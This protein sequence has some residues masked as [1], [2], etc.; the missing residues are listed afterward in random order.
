MFCRKRRCVAKLQRVYQSSTRQNTRFQHTITTESRER[1]HQQVVSRSSVAEICWPYR[2]SSDTS[3]TV[4]HYGCHPMNVV[5]RT[6]LGTKYFPLSNSR[7][8]CI[9]IQAGQGNHKRFELSLARYVSNNT[10]FERERPFEFSGALS[11]FHPFVYATSKQ[12]GGGT[13]Q[14]CL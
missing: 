14:L 13:L 8:R 11:S 5:Y 9:I 4:L 6:R 12:R 1:L 7:C 3:R 2:S 10:I